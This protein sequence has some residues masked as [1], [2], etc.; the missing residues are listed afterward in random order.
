MHFLSPRAATERAGSRPRARCH[1]ERRGR[2]RLGADGVGQAAIITSR[3]QHVKDE[4]VIGVLIVRKSAKGRGPTCRI[5]NSR[6]L[7]ECG[8]AAHGSWDSSSRL[9]DSGEDCDRRRRVWSERP[10]TGRHG[11]CS[12]CN[13]GL[14]PAWLGDNIRWGA[15]RGHIDSEVR[16]N[17][18]RRGVGGMMRT[19]VHGK[20]GRGSAPTMR[21]HKRRK[22]HRRWKGS[23]GAVIGMSV[24]E[25]GKGS[26]Q[27]RKRTA[28]HRPST[29]ETN[30]RHSTSHEGDPGTNCPYCG[31]HVYFL[32]QSEVDMKGAVSVREKASHNQRRGEKI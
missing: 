32:G 20:L 8:R 13:G 28:A 10:S 12:A 16:S 14:G 22:E 24:S 5:D 18:G 19:R 31:K 7:R 26:R 27:R 17:K 23:S 21:A 4:A 30:W 29:R 25:G 11:S 15:G 1:G 2:E 6:T 3:V 9:R